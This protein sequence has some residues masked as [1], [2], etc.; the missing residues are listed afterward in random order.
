MEEISNKELLDR[1]RTLLQR[2][3]IRLWEAPYTDLTTGEES[4]PD[5]RTNT[6]L[7]MEE[8]SLRSHHFRI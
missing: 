2:D 5:V 6:S 3:K 4:L 1:V 8:R 7:T